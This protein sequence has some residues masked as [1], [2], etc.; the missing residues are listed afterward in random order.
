MQWW[1]WVNFVWWVVDMAANRRREQTL[2]SPACN[3]QQQQ[4]CK[5][6]AGPTDAPYGNGSTLAFTKSV[7]NRMKW[8]EIDHHYSNIAT[9]FS[10]YFTKLKHDR[11]TGV[12]LEPFLVLLLSVQLYKSCEES[13]CNWTNQSNIF[14]QVP[15]PSSYFW[16]IEVDM[17]HSVLFCSI[18]WSL[19]NPFFHVQNLSQ[20]CSANKNAANKKILNFRSSLLLL[21]W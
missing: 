6:H 10:E 16:V 11:S 12:G 17:N 4:N 19:G 5:A 14:S 18:C 13:H 20:I 21:I 15:A 3:K 9:I 7:R 8:I 1:Y 2:Q